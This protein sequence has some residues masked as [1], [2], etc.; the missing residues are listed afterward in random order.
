[1]SLWPYGRVLVANRPGVKCLAPPSSH[2]PSKQ[3]RTRHV[4]PSAS[5]SFR[6]KVE[7]RSRRRSES[8]ELQVGTRTTTTTLGD[9]SA[10]I[11]KHTRA[12]NTPLLFPLRLSLR[13]PAMDRGNNKERMM[14]ATTM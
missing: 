6:T 5:A 13:F 9:R 1:M 8:R 2:E 7:S 14:E 3:R 11:C 10:L 4:S 12:L